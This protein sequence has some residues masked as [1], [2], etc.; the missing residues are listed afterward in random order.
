[1][2]LVM[3]IFFFFL[4]CCV[5][6]PATTKMEKPL[7]NLKFS[8]LDFQS[9]LRVIKNGRPMPALKDLLQKKGQK[10]A[11]RSF[12][13][14]WYQRKDW[15]C[16]CATKNRLYCF[17]CILF[18]KTQSSWTNAGF[19][20]LKNLSRSLAKHEKS[21]NHIQCQIDLKTFGASR[22]DQ[23]L[24]KHWRLNVS[25]H[26]AKVKENRVILKDLIDV[27]YFL[28]KQELAFCANDGSSSSSNC[29]NFVELLHAFAE[30]DANLAKHLQTSTVFCDLSNRIQ[31]NLIEAVADVI[32]NDI[33]EEVNT[34]PFVAVQ[35]DET[36]DGGNKAQISV[37]LRYVAKTVETWEVKEA[38]LGFQE[39]SDKQ[40]PA[41]ADYVLG[42]LGKYNCVEK[43]VA[44]T[45]DGA[46]VM[47][48]DLNV[49]VAK[50][51]EKVPE[52][53]LVHCSAHNLNL[54]LMNSAK[55]ISQCRSFFKT[56][57]G[58]ATFF[59]KWSKCTQ[60]LN[61]VVKRRL[62][63]AVP[64]SW[65]SHSRLVQIISMY[66]SD[67]RAA[68]QIISENPDGWDSDILI[69][70][71]GYDRWLSEA[72]TC[73][74]I[75]AYEDIFNETDGLS[76]LLQNKITEI[77]LCCAKVHVIM[78]IMECQRAEFDSFYERFQQ[79]CVT[80]GLADND[81]SKKPT[82]NEWKR[83]FYNILDNVSAQMKARFDHLRYLTF[84]DLAD[85][86]KFNEISQHFD[87]A[88]LKSLS[89]YARY[90]DIA[91]LKSDLIGLY[92]SKLVRNDCKSPGQLLSFLA[93]NDLMQTVPEAT[94]L[95]QLVLTIPATVASAERPFAAMK[96]LKTYSRN[97]TD[98]KGQ[99]SSLAIISIE[100]ER[101]L[102]LKYKGDLY[103]KV[104]NIFV[105]KDG[106][107]DFIY[108]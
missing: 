40:A 2:Y 3:V 5:Y 33:K 49:V 26:N 31:N 42:L 19:C 10:S 52:A 71:A 61:D 17:P 7:N 14:E 68:F 84:L 63:K 83:M 74:F 101:L 51:K 92:S 104:T 48:S 93:Q 46:S 38:F 58:L 36:T 11:R 87:E 37:I 34:A 80:L 23:A 56:V 35:V 8:K 98:D 47:A 105:Q 65:S 6:L 96:R 16:G 85:C 28:A 18:S 39:I 86:T 21:V 90:F 60:L 108:K 9:K 79:K 66:Q 12:Q 45:Y 22:K 106:R 94:K 77:G 43:L 13:M 91:R 81:Q 76:R 70:A 89:N 44:Q 53:T 25:I 24:D 15:L 64:T 1:M 88:K 99:H 103:N 100:R 4:I 78:G 102:K 62:P 27:T 73:F 55:S 54:V 59:L 97:Q 95:I 20:D 30:K 57:E 29:G 41:I 69:L 67:L 107:M 32:R 75:M 72:S 82:R 50:I